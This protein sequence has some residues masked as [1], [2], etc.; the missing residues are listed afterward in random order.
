MFGVDFRL[1]HSGIQSPLVLVCN[2]DQ[3][4]RRLQRLYPSQLS[5]DYIDL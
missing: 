5:V 4:E 2:E 3:M 1:R